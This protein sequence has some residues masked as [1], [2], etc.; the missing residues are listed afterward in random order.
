M[1]MKFL[2]L[3]MAKCNLKK[4]Q[5]MTE[6]KKYPDHLFEVHSM[7]LASK[8]QLVIFILLNLF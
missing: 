7:F 2:S 3:D 8:L 4:F 6:T 5:E 1:C